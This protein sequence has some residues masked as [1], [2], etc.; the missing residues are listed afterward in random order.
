[1]LNLFQH[2]LYCSALDKTQKKQ[3]AVPAPFSWF[4]H[5]NF[6]LFSNKIG[7]RDIVLR[8]VLK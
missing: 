5:S 3:C 7:L 2:L 8:R 6:F 1:M 4:I